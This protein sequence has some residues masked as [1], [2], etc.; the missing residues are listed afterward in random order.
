MRYLEPV[1]IKIKARG[2]ARSVVSEIE[3][4]RMDQGPVAP[5]GLYVK[6]N[7]RPENLALELHRILQNDGLCYTFE[8]FG[9]EGAL[10]N[11]NVELYYR[12][13]WLEE[14][15]DA[16]FDE[17]NKWKLQNYPDDGSDSQCLFSWNT[18]C[19]YCTYSRGWHSK[20]GWITEKAYLDHIEQDVYGLREYVEE[21]SKFTR[22][23]KT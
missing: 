19:S 6:Q 16:I 14:A 11:D 1:T 2:D 13:W 4:D 22:F 17:D 23:G 21:N 7:G 3:F 20:Y 5:A 15:M 12:G 8:T 18:I 9:F 10:P